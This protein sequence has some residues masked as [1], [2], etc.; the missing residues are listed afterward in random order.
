ELLGNQIHFVQPVPNGSLKYQ[1]LSWLGVVDK[2]R[3]AALIDMIRAHTKQAATGQTRSQIQK[4]F[5]H[6][7][8]RMNDEQMSFLLQQL[9][10]T[11]WLPAKGDLTQWYKPAELYTD[12]QEYLFATQANFLDMPGQSRYA[13]F[14]RTLGIKDKPSTKLVVNHLLKMSLLEKPVNKQ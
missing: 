14:I 6:L 3:E 2:P 8:N 4:L 9:K 1:F 5:S 11:T 10:D 7:A 13:H 12:Y